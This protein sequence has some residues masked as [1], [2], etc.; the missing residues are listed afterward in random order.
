MFSRFKYQGSRDKR[1]YNFCKRP[2]PSVRDMEDGE[3]IRLPDPRWVPP[4]SQIQPPARAGFRGACQGIARSVPARGAQIGVH[5][6][7]AQD[8]RK[9]H[10]DQRNQADHAAGVVQVPAVLPGSGDVQGKAMLTANGASATTT[11]AAASANAK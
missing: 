5:L 8:R 6:A 7:A 10:R 1:I 3:L 4:V 11:K 9:R 2:D